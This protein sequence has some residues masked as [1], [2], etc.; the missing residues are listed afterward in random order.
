MR[1]RLLISFTLI[2]LVSVI[3]VVV[4][5]RQGATNEVRAFMYRGGMSGSGGLV[6]EL[7]NYYARNRSWQG[8]E[9]LLVT[10]GRGQGQGRGGQGAGM[11]NQHLRL[12]DE[13]G[14]LIY[15]TAGSPTGSQLAATELAS[16]IPLTSNGQVIGYLLPDG[17]TGFSRADENFLVSRINRAA[18]I[19]GLI[20]AGLS[21]LLASF[22]AYRLLHP[23]RELTQAAEHLA[24]GDLSQRV[25]VRGKD[26]LATLGDTFNQ[27]AVSLQHA[28]ESRRAMTADIAHE[29]RNPLAVQRANLEALQDGIYPLSAEN[30]APVLEQNELLSRL[31]EDLG[32]LALADAG[33]LEL[34]RVNTDFPALVRRVVDKFR[35]QT[36]SQQIELTFSTRGLCPTLSLD[37]LRIEQILGNLLSN[38]L[39]YTPQGGRIEVNTNCTATSAQLTIRDNG[40]GLPEADLPFIFERFY[41]VD[42]A[43]S[44][45]EGGTGLGLAIARQLARAHGGSLTAANHPQ[46]GAQFILELKK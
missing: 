44:R 4:I 27:M 42:K 43:R 7:E 46:G 16:A 39:R 10:P 36:D 40:P 26:E 28:E 6:A 37:P 15:D 33:Q 45:S 2:V 24:L 25:R 8:V 38:A 17:G 20:A 1:I 18:L 29:L 21:L 31:V 23:I 41:R 13:A 5:F 22:L 9:R 32:T 12:A 3:G 14:V 35:P 19:A 34:E 11:M 30:L